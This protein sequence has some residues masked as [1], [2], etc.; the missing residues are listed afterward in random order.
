MMTVSIEY[1]DFIN[2]MD[3]MCDDFCYF[4]TTTTDPEV[5]E[6][7]CEECPMNKLLKLNSED[8]EE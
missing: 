7:H 2:A 4:R 1:F 6:K 3:K 8:D 5:L